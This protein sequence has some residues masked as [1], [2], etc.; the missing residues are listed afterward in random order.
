M[1]EA[2]QPAV[3]GDSPDAAVMDLLQRAARLHCLA[4]CLAYPAPG[5]RASV[6]ELVDRVGEVEPLGTLGTVWRGADEDALRVAYSRLFLG[7]APCPPNETA[8]GDARRLTGVAAELADIQGFYRAFG[9]QL[10]DDSRDMPDHVCAELEFLAVLLVKIAYARML[11][12]RDAGEVAEHAARSF[13]EQHPG[14]W[15]GTFAERVRELGAP[16]PYRE[17]ADAVAALIRTECEQHGAR[18][19]APVSTAGLER[20]PEEFTCPRA[21]DL[22]APAVRPGFARRRLPVL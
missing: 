14:R 6:L 7:C 18:P 21:E 11:G 1:R 16:S 15:A 4:R 5:H 22:G 9:F 12:W 19:A 3:P 2:L 8:W 20:E 13:L 10:A 17:S